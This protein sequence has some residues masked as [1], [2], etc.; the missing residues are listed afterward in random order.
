M[1]TKTEEILKQL[2]EFNLDNIAEN[3]AQLVNRNQIDYKHVISAQIRNLND[4][5]IKNSDE[6]G[7]SKK[8]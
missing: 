7:K 4:R 8:N 5:M 2:A 3:S 6:I 1:N